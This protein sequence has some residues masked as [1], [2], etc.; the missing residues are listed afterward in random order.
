VAYQVVREITY[1]TWD[2]YEGDYEI[3]VGN[4]KGPFEQV[5]PV[6]WAAWII[7]Q[8]EQLFGTHGETLMHLK[9][10]ADSSPLLW[11]NYRVTAK[12]HDAI[13]QALIYAIAAAVV[14][15]GLVLLTWQITNAFKALGPAVK[16]GLGILLA[17]AGVALVIFTWSR[18]KTAGGN[19]G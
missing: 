7:Q 3:F 15:I 11:T 19:H 18:S 4:F 17:A 5:L 16:A 6:N 13:P 2:P 9:I 14:L 1:P 12:C 8:Y 10:E